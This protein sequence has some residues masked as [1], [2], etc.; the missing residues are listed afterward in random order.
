MFLKKLDDNKI[1]LDKA[2]TEYKSFEYTIR[3]DY[4]KK[5]MIEN[6]FICIR[7]GND[8]IT[9]DSVFDDKYKRAI[10]YYEKAIAMDIKFSS[11]ALFGKAWA[12]LK[13]KEALF[14][15]NS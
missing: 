4:H 12:L 13:G 6:P 10:E 9:N 1:P 14:G 3:N 2:E 5:E 11:A 7:I 8:F 15:S